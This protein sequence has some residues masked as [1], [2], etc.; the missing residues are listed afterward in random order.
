M[1]AGPD[2]IDGAAWSVRVVEAIDQKEVA[3]DVTFPVVLPRASEP[4]IP[5]FGT[6]R[7]LVGDER[8]HDRLQPIHIVSTG[9]G[10]ALP[11]LAELPGVVDLAR[12]FGP[13]TG[14]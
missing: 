6:E 12:Q 1:S 7:R 14:R 2:K 9:A 8:E 13:F 10:E 4:M 11:V 3:T 5:L